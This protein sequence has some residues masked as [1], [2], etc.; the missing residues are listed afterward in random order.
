MLTVNILSLP[1]AE[2]VAQFKF[3]VL[4]MPN[5]PQK[6][7]GL[8]FDPTAFQSENSITDEEVKKLITSSTRSKPNKKKKPAT[9]EVKKV[10]LSTFFNWTLVENTDTEPIFLSTT[11]SSTCNSQLKPTT[12]RVSYTSSP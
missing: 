10:S 5:G 12:T 9:T 3:T 8:P 2:I 7:T 11:G 6:I 1:T 4:L